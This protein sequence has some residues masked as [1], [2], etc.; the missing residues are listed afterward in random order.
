MIKVL[1]AQGVNWPEIWDSIR[2]LVI[3]S[4]ISVEPM[5]ANNLNRASRNRH[6]CFE[7][8]GFDV[9]LDHNLKPWLLEINVLPSLSSSSKLDKKVKTALMTDVFSVIGITPYN[10]KKLERLQEST[11]W[12]RFS[13]M[14]RDKNN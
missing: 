3:K 14:Y 13:G 1:E 6:L 2:D 8:Y 11:K 5:L 7:V 12:Y 4:I 9:I 10:K